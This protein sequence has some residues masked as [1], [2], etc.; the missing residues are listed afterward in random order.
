MYDLIIIGAGTAGI[1]AYNEAIKYTQNI[2]IINDGSWDTTCARVGC[3]P[4]KLLISS[5]NRMHD[6]QTAEE[7]TL[8]HNAVI[9]T[10]DVMQRVHVLRERFIRATLKGVDQWDS[11]HKISGKAKFIDPQTIEVNGQSYRAKSFIVAVGSRPNIDETLK[12]QLKEKYITSNEIF[13][14]SQLPKSLAVIGSGIIAIE[15]AQAMQ[16]LGVQTTMFARS[17]KVGALTSPILQKLAQEQLS[18]ELNIKFKTLPDEIEIQTDKIIKINFT[19][20]DQTKSIEVEY[21]LGA[22]GRQS[23]IDRLGLDQLNSTF[24]DIKN[25]PI[26]KETKRLANLPIF[27]V[28]D[29]APDAPIQHEAAHTGKQVVHNCLNYP[30]VKPISALIPLAIVFCHPEMAIVGKSFKHLE[31]QQIEFIRGFVSYENQGRALVLAENSGG[32]EVYIAKK[33]GKL[34]GAELFCSQAEHLAHLLAWMIDADQD[35]YQILKKPFYHPT[36]EEGLRTAFKHARRQL[37]AL[38]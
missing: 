30:E 8:K 31:D 1:S 2:L 15:L 4:S 14:F 7:L 18:K 19:E 12:Q 21:V 17:Q 33:S 3:M 36:L 11:S 23:N 32:I 27:I 22:T 16:R 10:S 9:D 28:G 24:K 13:E 26:D 6:I 35:I 34:L 20:N 37:D 38:L 25:L 5:A 29:A